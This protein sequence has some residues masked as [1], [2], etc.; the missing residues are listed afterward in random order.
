MGKKLAIAISVGH[1]G[2]YSVQQYPRGKHSNTYIKIKLGATI[3]GKYVYTD[4]TWES[5]STLSS[6]HRQFFEDGCK[7]FRT[8]LDSNAAK[9][10]TGQKPS[11]INWGMPP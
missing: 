8:I 7:K 11:N 4:G 6:S 3:V 10:N 2:K 9:L 5:G 1:A